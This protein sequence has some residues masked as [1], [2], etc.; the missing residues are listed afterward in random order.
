MRAE[1]RQADPFRAAP[2]PAAAQRSRA[3]SRHGAGAAGAPAAGPPAAWL[4]FDYARFAE[5]FRGSRSTSPPARNSTAVFPGL[6]NVLDIGCG[7]G[8]F[9]ELMRDAGVPARGID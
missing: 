8:E 5:R 3:Q 1:F 9:L 7:R 4:A 6:R 2:H